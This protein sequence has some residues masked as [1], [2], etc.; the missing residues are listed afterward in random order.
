MKKI[1]KLLSV[2]S[3]IFFMAFAVNAQASIDNFMKID[4]FLSK[5]VKEMGLLTEVNQQ[6]QYA[7]QLNLLPEEIAANFN[8]INAQDFVTRGLTASI[9]SFFLDPNEITLLLS[10]GAEGEYV[11]ANVI[12]DL[13]QK[14]SYNN[15]V[16]TYRKPPAYSFSQKLETKLA[17]I[18][19]EP[20]SGQ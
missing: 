14:C 18:Y 3:V 10:Q 1:I 8:Q 2:C 16:L 15:Q 20:V 5:L 12:F 13:F 17:D 6:A 7:D 19:E 11:D 4:T 9:F